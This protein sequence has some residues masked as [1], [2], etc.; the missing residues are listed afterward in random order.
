M[1]SFARQSI[2]NSSSSSSSTISASHNNAAAHFHCSTDRLSYQVDFAECI[3][4]LYDNV[5]DETFSTLSTDV[6]DISV[7]MN[8]END[9][10]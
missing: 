6:M 2:A 9:F 1:G 4:L 7:F 8:S 10:N 5:N 3:A